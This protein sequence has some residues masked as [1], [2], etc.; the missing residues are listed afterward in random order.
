[1]KSVVCFLLILFTILLCSCAVATDTEGMFDYQISVS[2][3]EGTLKCGSETYGVILDFERS[4]GKNAILKSVEYTSPESIS[5]LVFE[6]DEDK[7]AVKAGGISISGENLDREKIF[8]AEKMFSL[9]AEDIISISKDENGS[10]V[11]VGENGS[12]KWQAVASKDGTPKKITVSD[13]KEEEELEI[14]NI[15]FS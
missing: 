11:T 2:R 1:M 14:E 13:G 10:T 12:F 6:K 9:N 15:K 5:G 4:E 7:I 8:F 3:V